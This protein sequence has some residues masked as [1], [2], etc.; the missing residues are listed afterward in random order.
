MMSGR[1]IGVLVVLAVPLVNTDSPPP[2]ARCQIS[3]HGN[4]ILG[5]PLGPMITVTSQQCS[6]R[7]FR[8]MAQPTI[9]L[10]ALGLPCHVRLRVGFERRIYDSDAAFASVVPVTDTEC[11]GR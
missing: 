5:L 2:V 3:S 7:Q 1:G 6:D 8:P 10:L 4:K 11:A 9:W